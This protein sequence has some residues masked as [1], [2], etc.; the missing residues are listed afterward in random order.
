[1]FLPISPAIRP[2]L[3]ILPSSCGHAVLRPTPVTRQQN[4]QKNRQENSML[5]S[6]TFA[7]M[8]AIFGCL[9]AAPP[10]HAQTAS[11]GV[12]LTC[13][14]GST[15]TG[16]SNKG[17]CAHHGGVAPTQSSASSSTMSPSA[18]NSMSPSN[19]MAPAAA[20]GG[21]AGKVWVNS[22]SKI[23]HCPGDK[24]YGKTKKGEY[25]TESAA[26]AAGNKPAMGKSCK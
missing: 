25:M 13:K 19:G 15:W 17:A 8:L 9:A 6:L 1:M 11:T 16:K 23:Y 7:V 20:A 21:G 2:A 5:R 12:T 3:T 10:V 24:Y 18:S 14:D 22:S 26:L 4:R